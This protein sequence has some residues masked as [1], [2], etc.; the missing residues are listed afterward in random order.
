MEGVVW[1]AVWEESELLLL[2]WMW[3]MGGSGQQL[4]AEGAAL[5]MSL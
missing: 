4:A 2:K 5:W 1:T 3:C